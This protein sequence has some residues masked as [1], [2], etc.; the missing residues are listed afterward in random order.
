MRE[1]SA[2]C[3]RAANEQDTQVLQGDY[4]GSCGGLCMRWRVMREAVIMEGLDGGA[5][6][7]EFE[8]PNGIRGDFDGALADSQVP[9]MESRHT[10]AWRKMLDVN[11]DV[12]EMH[13]G[14]EPLLVAVEYPGTAGT[15]VYLLELAG[16]SDGKP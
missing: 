5:E 7:E 11:M 16:T 8:H 14:L 2:D 4:R 1:N 13:L 3:A 6:L 15:L 10:I 12:D 9:E